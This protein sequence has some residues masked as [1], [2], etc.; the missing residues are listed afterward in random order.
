MTRLILPIFLLLASISAIAEI[1]EDVVPVLTYDKDA[2]YFASFVG[3]RHLRFVAEDITFPEGP[4]K[5]KFNQAL[6]LLEEVLNSDEFK[7]KVI[8]YTRRGERSYQKNYIWSQT[9]RRLTNEDIYEIIMT[10]NEKMRPDTQGEMNVNAWVKKCSF[11]EQVSVWC[12]KVIGSTDPASSAMIKL[13]WK[14]Y[15]KYET[16]HMVANLVHE[17]IHLLGFLHGSENLHEEVPY[18]VGSIAGEVA[19][20]ILEREAQ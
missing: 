15:Q 3:D 18:V 2:E 20:N 6:S 14:F 10:G 16:H 17:W 4:Q 13:N 1:H 5:E 9:S 19:K 12:R 8:G 11:I 7:A